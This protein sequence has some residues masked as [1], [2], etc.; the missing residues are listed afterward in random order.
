MGRYDEAIADGK[1]ASAMFSAVAG[2]DTPDTA[3]AL[4]NLALV[5]LDAESATTRRAP[6]PRTASRSATS[7]RSAPRSASR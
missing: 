6:W 3:I 5:M 2:V 7:S 1:A 4:Y